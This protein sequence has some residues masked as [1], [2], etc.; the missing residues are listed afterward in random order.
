M[1]QGLSASGD[2][3]GA[4]EGGDRDG[5]VVDDAVDHHLGDLGLDLGRVDGDLRQACTALIGELRGMLAQASVQ[6]LEPD[7]IILDEFQRFHDLL[8]GDNEAADLASQLFNH[9]DSAGN[10]AK[11]LLL[12]ATPYRM[13]TLSGDEPDDGE[14]YRDFLETLSF[15]YGRTNGPD[16]AKALEREMREFR[17]FLVREIAVHHRQRLRWHD[18]CEALWARAVEIGK[19]KRREQ[20]MLKR[21][22]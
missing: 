21:S 4:G 17:G 16:V 22:L 9:V 14:H 2:D 13:L 11:T 5:G 15:L 1:G 10:T 19:V 20:R 3:R 6:S 7:L 18:R 8:H 12:S